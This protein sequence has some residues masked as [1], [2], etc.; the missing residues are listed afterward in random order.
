MLH[1]QGITY[2]PAEEG[3]LLELLYSTGLRRAE[4]MRLTVYDIEPLR[5]IVRADG[6]AQT[7]HPLHDTREIHAD[8]AVNVH[9]KFGGMADQRGH[10]CGG[11]QGLE[12]SAHRKL[13]K[14]AEVRR[15][16]SAGRAG[17]Q[18]HLVKT[19]TPGYQKE[20]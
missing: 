3:A 15:M 10:F 11:Q 14:E 5:G 16:L 19:I 1:S 18:S 4:A 7:T 13:Q 6:G 12:A 2:L 17:C 8:R 20:A 9:A